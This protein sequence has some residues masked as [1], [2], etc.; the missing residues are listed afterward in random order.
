MRWIPVVVLALSTGVV[1]TSSL[2]QAIQSENI[3]DESFFTGLVTSFDRDARRVTVREAGSDRTMT[4]TI[5]ADARVLRGES[6][7]RLDAVAV[8][9]PVTIEF[10]G[11]A[12]GPTVTAVKV[13]APPGAE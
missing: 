7:Y 13:I 8:G 10:H 6:P 1:P 2:A 5:P 4:F 11:S 12:R 3:R 9:D